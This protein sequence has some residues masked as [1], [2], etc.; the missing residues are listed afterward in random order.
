MPGRPQTAYYDEHIS[1]G[2]HPP[3]SHTLVSLC[4]VHFQRY[5]HISTHR[6]RQWSAP[7]IHPPV[8]LLSR[9]AQQRGVKFYETNARVSKWLRWKETV[10]SFCIIMR[11]PADVADKTWGKYH[12]GDRGTQ[13]KKCT[14]KC[15]GQSKF[16]TFSIQM[17]ASAYVCPLM[18]LG[19]SADK[20]YGT[21]ASHLNVFMRDRYPGSGKCQL[22]TTTHTRLS[23]HSPVPPTPMHTSWKR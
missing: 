13:L 18:I 22:P 6:L 17:F 10:F 16:R 1:R 11:R 20:P 2:G 12:P 4:V 3:T 19:G 14:P 7:A 21:I 9:A 5:H 8:V 23:T 15:V